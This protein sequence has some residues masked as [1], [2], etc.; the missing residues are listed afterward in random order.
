MLFFTLHLK[1]PCF[2]KQKKTSDHIKSDF[3]H[4][5][6]RFLLFFG[7]FWV[8]RTFFAF[9][10]I[11]P[12]VTMFLIKK[13]LHSSTTIRFR[14]FFWL[15]SVIF[16]GFFGK[17]QI[18]HKIS[19]SFYLKQNLRIFLTHFIAKSN[20]FWHIYRKTQCVWV[21]KRESEGFSKPQ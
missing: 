20:A 3:S 10:Q 13:V 5:F 7:I 16:W 18:W 19:N 4:F 12:Q 14:S 21:F 15:I 6:G 11:I 17:K 2:F 1:I 9:L 8:W